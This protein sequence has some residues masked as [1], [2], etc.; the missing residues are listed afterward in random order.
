MY[1]LGNIQYNEHVISTPGALISL[2]I[3]RTTY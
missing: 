1:V 2:E 3:V